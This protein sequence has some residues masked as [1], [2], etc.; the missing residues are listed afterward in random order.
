MATIFKNPNY[1]P[2]DDCYEE[3][4]PAYE[5]IDLQNHNLGIINYLIN[6]IN[7]F[8]FIESIEITYNILYIM[9]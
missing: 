5:Y 2:D 1:K 7:W 8:Y 6:Q 3:I 4:N 9:L